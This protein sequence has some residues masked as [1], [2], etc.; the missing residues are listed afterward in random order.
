MVN[1]I[2]SIKEELMLGWCAHLCVAQ[3]QQVALEGSAENI[4][5]GPYLA[6]T[7]GL[8]MPAEGEGRLTG[9]CTM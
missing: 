3:C 6:S 9:A 1:T 8:A 4:Y 5:E 2:S 7:R